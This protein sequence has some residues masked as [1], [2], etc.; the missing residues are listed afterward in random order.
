MTKTALRESVGRSCA[1]TNWGV[2]ISW[3]GY[4]LYRG[5]VDSFGRRWAYRTFPEGSGSVGQF[6]SLREM[7]AWV[8]EVETMRAIDNHVAHNQYIWS[9]A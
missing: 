4:A 2:R 7:V 3:L 6:S 5:S 8:R 9:R 1:T